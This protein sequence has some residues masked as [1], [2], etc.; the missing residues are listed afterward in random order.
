MTLHL[1]TASPFSSPALEQCL[2]QLGDKDGILLLEDGV[3]ALNAPSWQRRLNA[4]NQPVY[5]LQSDCLAR[6]MG[7]SPALFHSVDMASVVELT[8]EYNNSLTWT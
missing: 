8:L 1:V 7:E 4:L 3:Y 6:G 2:A 5:V